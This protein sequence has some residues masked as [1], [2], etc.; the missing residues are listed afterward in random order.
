M[1]FANTRKI[2]FWNFGHMPQKS[3]RAN[4]RDFVTGAP[5]LLKRLQARDIIDNLAL[6]SNETVLDLG[7]GSGYI[8][9]ELAKVSK[10]VIGVDVLDYVE[11]IAIPNELK[12][13]L[14]FKRVTDTKLPFDDATFDKALASEV[15]PMIPEPELF[16]QELKRILKPG[17]T[18]VICNGVGHPAIRDAYSKNT[19]RLMR[20]K[21]KYP[22]NFPE[23]YEAYCRSLQESFVTA[24][25]SFM[26]EEEIV[27]LLQKEGFEVI[28]RSYSPGQ[29]AGEHI[30]WHQFERF[31]SKNN[32][33]GQDYF[34]P[35]YY[36]FDFLRH[37]NKTKYPGGFICQA[38]RK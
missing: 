8:T 30:S 22:E 2:S 37:F 26:T 10:K 20:L 32:T 13:R 28:A 27:S 15:L 9:L 11:D 3:F 6:T 38:L 36:F 29:K 5:N 31:L 14:E 4:I 17:G 7:C 12:G 19:T 35:K 24:R 34:I 21:E 18:L 1:K 25:T 33:L 16:L 23:N